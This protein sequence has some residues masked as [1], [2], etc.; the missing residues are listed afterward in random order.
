MQNRKEIRQCGKEMVDLVVNLL[1]CYLDE[2]E[3]YKRLKDRT[4]VCIESREGIEVLL[5]SQHAA[6][7]L[8]H[9][10]IRDKLF[11]AGIHI[12][13]IRGGRVK[14]L[15]GLLNLIGRP[16]RGYAVVNEKAEK[17]FLYGRDVFPSSLIEL[18][19]PPEH[20]S[21]IIVVLNPRY[22]PIGW[23]KLKP[24]KGGPFIQNLLDLGWYLRCGV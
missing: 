7:M 9:Q 13:R 12:A 14:P 5:C 23:G 3:A 22:E 18:V 19:R 2:K 8:T 11:T 24:T 21:N 15:L 6:K 20:C 17:L 4:L 1:S 16:S 10:N